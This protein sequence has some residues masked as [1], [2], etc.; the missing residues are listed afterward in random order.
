MRRAVNLHCR[1]WQN[2]L[3]LFD[4]LGSL[5]CQFGGFHM[6]AT[7][8]F[9]WPA[10][11]PQDGVWVLRPQSHVFLLAGPF[12]L[13]AYSGQENWRVQSF[14]TN[15]RITVQVIMFLIKL[16]GQKKKRKKRKGKTWIERRR[17]VNILC[18]GVIKNSFRKKT[19]C[20][21]VLTASWKAVTRWVECVSG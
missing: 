20:V 12:S 15:P 5:L 7:V 2:Y 13:N 3:E 18:S 19:W 10:M 4:I 6:C 16:W 17:F 8:P 11:W 21:G 9:C 1:M 14:G